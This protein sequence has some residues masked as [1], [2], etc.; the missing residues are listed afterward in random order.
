MELRT[1]LKKNNDRLEKVLAQWLE[2]LT[3]A[4]VIV[5]G[6]KYAV[7][8]GGKRIRPNLLFLTLDL[9]GTPTEKGVPTAAAI[10]II[11]CYSLVHDDLPAMDNDDYRRGKLT[12][13][14]KFGE[15]QGILI[16]DA[17][18]TY[19]FSVLSG[20]N[21]GLLPAE[22][23]TA[24]VEKTAEYSGIAGMIGG[25]AID[26]ESEGKKIDLATLRRMHL[27]KTGKLLKLPVECGCVI[28]G[29]SGEEAGALENYAELL[30]L[31][32]QI[33]DD[34]LDV[35]GDFEKLGKPIGSDVLLQKSTYPSV[36]GMEESKK[37]LR[38]TAEG[39]KNA[40]KEVFG[41]ERTRLLCEL[42][43]FFVNRDQ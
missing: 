28:A 40:L 24:L 42:A 11:H 1:Y 27:Y 21:R 16:G 30:G 39:A 9:L 20:K 6:M 33:K 5:A 41:D 8:D 15:A 43:D 13:H 14:K 10:E 32:F 29:A 25:Q 36:I 38:E 12:T 34:I 22:K 7:L 18:L 4:P 17:L 19:A 2:E 37:L 23:I 31:A 3:D 26:L 35:E